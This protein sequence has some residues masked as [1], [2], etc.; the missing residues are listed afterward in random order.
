M[1]GRWCGG[2][3]DS[4]RRRAVP[5]ADRLDVGRIDRPLH[6][7][8]FGDAAG[9]R[10]WMDGYLAAAL[11]RRSDPAHSADLALIGGLRSVRAVLAGLPAGRLAPDP[12]FAGFSAFVAE[13]PPAPRLEELRAPAPR[14]RRS[15]TRPAPACASWPE[16]PWPKDEERRR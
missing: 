5:V 12:W 4:G 2:S 7:I 3:G 11:E 8:R 13:G 6:G 10:R 16:T 9:L 14:R 15:G 1:E